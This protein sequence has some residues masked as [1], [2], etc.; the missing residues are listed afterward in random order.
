[1]KAEVIAVGSELTSGHRLDTNSQWI[2]Q[3]LGSAGIDVRHIATVGDEMTELVDTLRTAQVRS[4]LVIIG[5]GLGPTQ[6]DLTRA[7]LAELA[8]V[9]LVEDPA[10]LQ[11]IAALFERRNR[12]MPER[13]RVQALIPRGASA[14]PNPIGT[15]PGIW[16]DLGNTLYICLPGVPIELRTMFD[17]QVLPR[18]QARGLTRGVIL[19][20]VVNLFGKGESEIEAQVLDLTARGRDPEVGITAHEAT[21]SLRITASGPDVPAARARIQPTLELI[22]ARFGNLIVGEGS[23]DVPHALIAALRLRHATLAVAESCTGGLIAATL[24][25]I[26]DVSPVFLGGVVSYANAV[27]SRLLDV[28]PDL[29]QARGAV[30]PEVAQAMA[31]GAR[32]R[33]GADLGL[34]VTGIAGPSGGTPDKP[35]GLVYLGLADAK[36][37]SSRELRLG[38][39]QPRNVIQARAAKS[40]MNW[41]RLHL[42]ENL[43]HSL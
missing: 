28:P 3:R 15:A 13:N 14:L 30:S 41:A 20:H 42:M 31:A 21:I 2:A 18:L 35:V 6:D 27:K 17:D 16:F 11:A 12:P 32:V 7:A 38:P 40:A 25:S 34:A 43:P 29:I 36:G 19:H 33:L 5:G 4:S 26:P 39:E 9:E 1:M 22:R 23:E 24:T 8:G 37:V 10:S